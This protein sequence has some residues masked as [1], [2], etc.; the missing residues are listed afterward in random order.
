MGVSTAS[1][2]TTSTPMP[3]LVPGTP[4]SVETPRAMGAAQINRNPD[5]ARSVRSDSPRAS[6][7][8]E[9]QVRSPLRED[10]FEIP[11][12]YEGTDEECSI[13]REPRQDGEQVVGLTC[14]HVFHAACWQPWSATS[15]H[16]CCPNC[17]GAGV[18]IA[19]WRYMGPGP[20][21]QTV[22]AG[23]APNELEQ[24]AQMHNIA[25]PELP[26]PPT[27]RQ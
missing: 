15:H 17:R 18:C 12:I 9:R 11:I 23:A 3:P 25:A 7:V 24:H 20:D 4:D 22:G 19:M 13:C 10:N 27:P 2:L 14:R 1:S 21:T 6:E 5:D 16:R 26:T 8:R